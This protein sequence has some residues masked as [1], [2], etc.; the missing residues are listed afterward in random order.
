MTRKPKANDAPCVLTLSRKVLGV[1]HWIEP[2]T[3]Q[4]FWLIYK[5]FDG[6]LHNNLFSLE[7]ICFVTN[8]FGILRNQIHD[9][10]VPPKYF[11]P[12]FNSLQTFPPHSYF[13]C[14][15]YENDLLTRALK[16]SKDSIMWVAPCS[17]HVYILTLHDFILLSG[18]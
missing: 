14:F 16:S 13:S 6:I 5:M 3:W 2:E 9:I 12:I 1:S 15:C 8:K 18:P 7:Y 11:F 4:A 17:M 10:F